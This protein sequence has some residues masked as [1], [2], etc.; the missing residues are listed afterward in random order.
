M[1]T[2]RFIPFLLIVAIAI[3]GCKQDKVAQLNKLRKQRDELTDKIKLLEKEVN[4]PE[5]AKKTLRVSVSTIQPSQFKHYLEVQGRLDGEDNVDVFPEAQGVI[6]DV[7]VTVGQSVSKG[8][9]LA[10]MDIGPVKD[11]LKALEKQYQLAKET[12]EK[13]QRLWDQKIGS[14]MQYL[15]SKTAKEQLESQRDAL[16]KQIDMM[17]IKAPIAGTVEEVNV[18][19][20]QFASAATPLPPFRVL[21]FGSLKVKADVAEAYSKRVSVGDDVLVFFPDLNKEI[22]AKISTASRFISPTNRTFTIEVR[23]SPEKNGF[24]ANMVAVLKITDYSVNNAIVIP[25]NYVQSDPDGMFVY[26]A[27]TKGNKNVAKRVSVT[28]GQ[29]YNGMVEITKG[30][31]PGQKVITS[32]Y[33]DLEEGETIIF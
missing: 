7:L 11:Q 13:Q 24:K 12:Y 22:S 18:K 20:G 29:S 10:K 19:I 1:N 28:E 6:T 25:V 23:L 26:V 8:Q 31:T 33:L 15:Q 14:E 16:L 21:N 9:A 5:K 17:T 32:G 3:F 4:D 27:E 2:K 30:L